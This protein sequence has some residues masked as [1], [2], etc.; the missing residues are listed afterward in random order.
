MARSMIFAS[1]LPLTFWGDAVE[2]A[3][4]ILNRSP[5]SANLR[6]ASPLQLLTK[7][8]P[9]L[10]DVVVFG[11]TCTVYRDPRKNSLAQRAQVGIIVGRSDETKGYR[12]F[13]QKDNVV[14]V[15]QHVKNN[16]TLSDE[17]NSQLQRALEYDD[18]DAPT[19]SEG[20]ESA[21]EST[22]SRATASATMQTATTALSSGRQKTKSCTR[23]SHGTRGAAKRAQKTAAQEEPVRNTSTVYHVY[24]R[25]P[26]NYGEAMRSSKERLVESNAR[27]IGSA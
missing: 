12:V 15:T 23:S 26:K 16:A 22:T 7:V 25:D 19:A 4:Y 24:E 1:R 11:S 10:R 21:A 20:T 2:Y 14:V 6:R 13:L 17:Q 5:T 18:Q 27:R 8:A 9:D 3:V